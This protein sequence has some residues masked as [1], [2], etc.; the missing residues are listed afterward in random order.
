MN[1]GPNRVLIEYTPTDGFVN[2]GDF[3]VPSEKFRRDM[4]KQQKVRVINHS[5]PYIYLWGTL[6]DGDC[7][8]PLGTE[9]YFNRHDGDLFEMNKKVYYSV[10]CQFVIAYKCVDN[11]TSS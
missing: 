1:A 5:T 2:L 8:V 11:S 3:F 7:G 9:V 4:M 10:P 6:V